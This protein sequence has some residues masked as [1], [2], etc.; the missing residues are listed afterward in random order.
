[1][2]INWTEIFNQRRRLGRRT[3]NLRKREYEIR[4]KAGEEV[5]EAEI[6]WRRQDGDDGGREQRCA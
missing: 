5:E 6:K 3:S 4:Y 2:I 1:V